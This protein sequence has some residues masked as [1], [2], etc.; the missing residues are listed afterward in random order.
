[1]F[2]ATCVLCRFPNVDCDTEKSAPQQPRKSGPGDKLHWLIRQITGYDPSS[3]C[4]CVP[5]MQQM[6]QWGWLGCWRNR[7]TIYG[8]LKEEAA[9]RG[10]EVTDAKLG[11]LLKAAF[12]E[13]RKKGKDAP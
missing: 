9:K 13:W 8:W 4:L 10:V 12:K 1:M 11:S 5:R 2:E 3:G 7:T 6:N